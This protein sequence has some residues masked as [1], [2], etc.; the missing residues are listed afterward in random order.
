M[1][2]PSDP[3]AVIEEQVRYYDARAREYDDWFFRRGRYHRGEEE[4]AAWFLELEEVRRALER[5]PIDGAN[6]L[7]L[8]PGT[9]LWT[10]IITRRA[11]SVTA[12]DASLE[13]VEV[14]KD[15]LGATW[16]EVTFRLLDSMSSS[17]RWRRAPPPA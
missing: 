13:M 9:G 6:V 8:A 15:R 5:V 2:N 17:A 10:E 16:D 4:T 7:E 12:G 1:D 11:S 14:A 3:A